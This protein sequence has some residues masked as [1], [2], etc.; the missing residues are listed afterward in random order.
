MF[1]NVRCNVDHGVWKGSVFFQNGFVFMKQE[2]LQVF[3]IVFG[4][5]INSSISISSIV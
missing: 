1:P 3:E 4:Y 5:K 2:T